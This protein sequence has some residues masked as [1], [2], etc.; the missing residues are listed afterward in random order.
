[1]EIHT[2]IHISIASQ[3]EA[4]PLA[5]SDM[6]ILAI[7]V[8]Y[9]ERGLVSPKLFLSLHKENENYLLGPVKGFSSVYAFIS[10]PY[11]ALGNV[12]VTGESTV[13]K[14]DITHVK[15]LA[16]SGNLNVSWPHVT[17]N[18]SRSVQLNWVIITISINIIYLKLWVP[19]LEIYLFSCAHVILSDW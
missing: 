9:W 10:S 13:R 14:G 15:C 1:M 12:L 18:Y 4:F 17:N 3:K 16:D 11:Y 19:L 2:C 5:D 8:G 7:S 6:C